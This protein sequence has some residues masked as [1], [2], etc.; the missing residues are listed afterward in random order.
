MAIPT[1]THQRPITHAPGRLEAGPEL[2]RNN[3]RP[4]RPSR[5]AAPGSRPGAA[6]ILMAPD[7]RL[8]QPAAGHY[9]QTHAALYVLL[10]G[11]W[12][13]LFSACAGDPPG[14]APPLPAVQLDRLVALPEPS[15]E[16]QFNS[17]KMA[18]AAIISPQGTVNSYRPLQAYMEQKLGKPV[19]LVQRRTYQEV[20][21]LLARG[22]VDVAFV[23]TGPF[24]TGLKEGT[25]EM[26]VV[27]QVNGKITYQGVFIV[28]A[29]SRI[30]AL[31]GLRGKVFALT[32]PMSNTGYLY[33][34][35]V[36]QARGE[37]AEDFF[38]RIIFTYSHDRSIAAVLDG[39]VDGASVDKIVFDHALEADPSLRERF[40]ILHVSREFGIPPVVVP[41]GIDPERKRQLQEFFLNIH[42]DPEG[43]AILAELGMERF[44]EGDLKLYRLP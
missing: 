4:G 38:G 21:E 39:V 32:D 27:P 28:S 7:G 34:M 10:A 2:N 31:E 15:A 25:M 30:T 37:S 41:P 35:S 20:N 14:D 19:Q 44:T 6:A 42:H 23:C 1:F 9:Q 24:V 3:R 36:I 40:Q 13:L 33:P 12:L 5:P 17:L 22:L 16:E 18:V 26:L 11:L 29:A 43:A 8:P